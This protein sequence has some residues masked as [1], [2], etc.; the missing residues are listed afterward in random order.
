M[1]EKIAIGCNHLKTYNIDL[2]FPELD[3]WVDFLHIYNYK[4]NE[5]FTFHAHQN[6]E[7]HYYASGEGEVAFLDDQLLPNGL[8]TLPATVKS[9]KDPN[10]M[11]FQ[12]GT[13]DPNLIT[14][15][16]KLFQLKP[17]S[18]FFNCPGQ[19][20]L[21]KSSEHNPLVEYATRFSFNIK[22]TENP[23]NQYFIKEYK[24]IQQ[25]LS[26][27]I[28]NVFEDNGEIRA[29]Y[30]TIFLEAYYRKPAFLVKI[31]NELINLIVAYARLAWD[32]SK[33]SY[34]IPESDSTQKRLSMI[35]DYIFSNIGANITLQQLSKNIN[36]SERNLSRFIKQ[37]KGVAVH[38]Y[39]M[40]FRIFKAVTLIKTN[41]YSL[42]EIAA[43]TGFSSPFHLSKCIKKY[44]GKNPS[45][46]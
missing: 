24:L 27:S 1:D 26:Q 22:S 30:E 5:T 11:E 45:E 36:M 46:L 19:F 14:R 40:Q 7:F 23:V 18:V 44:T 28:V 25:L 38:Q 21:Q 13:A 10:L 37:R 4:P 33:L 32:E 16:T 42:T 17:G 29:I 39:I 43:L 31:K 35:D 2:N 12:F 15:K 34:F 6:I 3:I 41:T 9:K 8:I 20:C